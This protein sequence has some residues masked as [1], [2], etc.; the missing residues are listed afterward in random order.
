VQLSILISEATKAK[1]KELA[2]I[3]GKPLASIVEQLIVDKHNEQL[4]ST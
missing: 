3:T 2:E 1:L 4:L